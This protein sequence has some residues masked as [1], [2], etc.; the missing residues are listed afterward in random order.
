[1]TCCVQRRL[2]VRVIARAQHRDEQ[3]DLDDLAGL[4]V[5]QLRLHSCVVDEQ[6]IAGDVHLPHHGRLTLGPFAI[7]IAERGVS[8]PV[9]MHRQV[10]DVQER[11]RHPR[12][13]QLEVQRRAIRLRTHPRRRRHL[14]VQ[15]RVELRVAHRIDGGDVEPQRVR[16]G[17]NA[18]HFARA[19]ADRCRHLPV[20]AP[21]PQLLPQNLSQNVHLHSLRC[22]GLPYREAWWRH[23]EQRRPGPLPGCPYRLNEQEGT[24]VT[25]SSD[26]MGDTRPVDMGDRSFFGS[27][28][29][30]GSRLRSGVS[31]RAPWRRR[32]GCEAQEGGARGGR[33]AT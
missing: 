11:E 22:H 9:P 1:M 24:W 19:H 8:Q 7:P 13:T 25:L 5:E 27:F 4:R 3:L 21:Q 12:T 17:E 28:K 6:L 32:R 26:D 29:E 14:R 16:P 18:G 10:L 31:V 2:R 15:T 30:S 20:A 33:L 23:E